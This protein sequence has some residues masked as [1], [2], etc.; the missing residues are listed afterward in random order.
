MI[1]LITATG[2]MALIVSG[3]VAALGVLGTMF[4]FVKKSGVDQQKAK[5]AD[6]YAKHLQEISDAANARPVGGVQS[7]PNNRDN[8]K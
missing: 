8:A 3:V 5:E 6:S 7:D 4:H 2:K 1:D